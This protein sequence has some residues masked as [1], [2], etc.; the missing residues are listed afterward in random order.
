MIND[1]V[2]MNQE[3]ICLILT[4]ELG[5]SKICA[6]IVPRNL[7]GQRRD[8]WL[9]VCADL[10]QQVEADPEIMDQV[11]T[12]EKSWFFQYDPETKHQHL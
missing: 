6:K 3:T 11:I 9:S 8:A 12:G 7:T 10:L 1:E 2:N 4:E 5:M